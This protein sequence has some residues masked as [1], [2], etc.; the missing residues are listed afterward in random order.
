[1]CYILVGNPEQLWIE[2][3][4]VI[5]PV[6]CLVIAPHPSL[7]VFLHHTGHSGAVRALSASPTKVFSGSDDTTI[8]VCCVW[9]MMPN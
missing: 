1:M 5:T 2:G 4:L 9:I 6:R 7:M 8:K 3:V